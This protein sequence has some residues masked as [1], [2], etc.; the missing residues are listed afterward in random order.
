MAAFLSDLSEEEKN[1]RKKDMVETGNGG[2]VNREEWYREPYR[3]VELEE[4]TVKTVLA[5]HYDEK[6]RLL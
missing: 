2:Y 5:N 3:F 4:F 1:K 6:F